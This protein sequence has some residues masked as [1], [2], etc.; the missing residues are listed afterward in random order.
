MNPHAPSTSH[1]DAR[2]AVTG[3][4]PRDLV[5]QRLA[6]QA[7]RFPDLDPTGFDARLEPRDAAFAHAIYDA[8]IRRWLTLEV[9]VR[10]RMDKPNLP[11]DIG[12]QA[13]LLSGAAQ[14]VF[15]DR[16]P[17]HAVINHCVEWVKI[18]VNARAGG[19]VNALLRRVGELMASATNVDEYTIAHDEIPMEDGGAIRLPAPIFRGDPSQRLA[20]ATSHPPAY[21]RALTTHFGPDVAKKLALHSLVRPPTVLCT[22]YAK[23]LADPGL[24]PHASQ[25]HRVWTGDRPSMLTLLERERLVWVQDA[26]SSRAVLGLAARLTALGKTPRVIVD[27][28]AGQG[29]K[30]RQLSAEFPGAVILASDTDEDR[31][32]TLRA[33]AMT[34]GGRIQAAAY[35]DV[36]AVVRELSRGYGA[37]L[38][39]LD[40]PCSNAGTLARRPEAKYRLASDQMVR[41]VPLQ[42]EII[43]K[44]TSLLSPE[45]MLVY[46][47]CSIDPAENHDQAEWAASPDG[48]GLKLLDEEQTLPSGTPG[49]PAS[50]YGDGSY[51]A[52]LSRT[53]PA[54]PATP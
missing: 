24:A 2:K 47:T 50:A 16:V 43:A 36:P 17:T 52:L 38:V 1:P 39:L 46:S 21:I 35:E 18:A 49:D 29:T 28:C 53:Q 37:D 3:D 19:L 22:H 7:R 15:L 14:I 11:L 6:Q 48:P 26:S 34:T 27:L 12:V 40:V 30:T 9:L 31:L 41:L 54:P 33:G 51:F 45:G 8:V 25:A 32:K 20:A 10:S 44:G 23:P 13:A 4:K 42:R 5:C